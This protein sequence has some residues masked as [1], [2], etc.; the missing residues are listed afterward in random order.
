MASASRCNVLTDQLKALSLQYKI[1]KSTFEP[2]TK[3]IV[4][5]FFSDKVLNKEAEE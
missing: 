2:E 5:V 1:Y 4:L 3:V